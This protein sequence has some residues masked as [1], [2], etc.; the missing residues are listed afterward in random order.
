[1]I[2]QVKQAK[3]YYACIPFFMYSNEYKNRFTS[4]YINKS[5]PEVLKSKFWERYVCIF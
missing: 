1:M 2:G 4:K 3:A 5:S